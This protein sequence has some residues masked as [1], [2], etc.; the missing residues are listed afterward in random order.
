L[1]QALYRK[2][3]PQS[4]SELSGQDHIKKTLSNAV[5]KDKIVHAYIFDGPRGSGK[6]TTARILAK[7]INCQNR[8][9]AEPCNNCSSCKGIM[10]DSSLDFI[11][12]DAASNRGI[13]EIKDLREKV[14]FSPSEMKYKIF[15]IDEVHML[16]REAFNA[17]LK[18]LEEPPS[19]AIF[20]LATTEIHKVP[21]TI[22]SRCQRFDF[23]RL[24][25]SDLK[26]R[27]TYIAKKEGIE[28][29]SDAAQ[30]IALAASG[31]ARDSESMLDL[32]ITYGFKK[33]KKENIDEIL[34]KTEKEKVIQMYEY[35]SLNE[36]KKALQLL[37]DISDE[38]KD[39]F[40]FSLSVIEFLR[41]KMFQQG[42]RQLAQWVRIFASAQKEM[43]NTSFYSL[44]LELAIVEITTKENTEKKQAPS[45]NPETS[46]ISSEKSLPCKI[47]WDEVVYRIRPY[48]HSL[49]FLLKNCQPQEIIDDKLILKVDYK[50]HKD[51]LEE[52]KNRRVIEDVIKKI[53][54]SKLRLFCKI[55]KKAA[56]S[57]DDKSKF[58]KEAEELFNA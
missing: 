52:D 34:G 51:K 17:L 36:T 38:G 58:I 19:H 9:G 10:K 16:T 46:I 23:R 45:D 47:N 1:S 28:L 5:I 39:L 29:D 26:K 54:G 25:I 53:T 31:S 32:I 57:K 3:R 21:L 30:N 15:V 27:L 40:Q 13:E 44:P 41:E 8:K 50:F 6:T 7:A 33:I 20:I 18:T 35:L 48:N 2:W 22:I 14:K 55:E 49:C 43:K 12:I 11:E 42:S 37:C 24:S 4:F 56:V